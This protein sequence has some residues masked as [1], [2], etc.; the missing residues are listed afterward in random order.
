MGGGG[1]GAMSKFVH[2]LRRE[3]YESTSILWASY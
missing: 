1:G 3:F 2:Y